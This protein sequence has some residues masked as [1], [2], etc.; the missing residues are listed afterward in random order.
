[1]AEQ[2]S[3]TLAAALQVVDRAGVP[4]RRACRLKD[5]RPALLLKHLALRDGL[6]THRFSQ[7]A[8]HC[9]CCALRSV[10]TACLDGRSCALLLCRC[11]F[12]C[13]SA[14]L[15]VSNSSGKGVSVDGMACALCSNVS[16]DFDGVLSALWGGA[17]RRAD[18]HILPVVAVLACATIAVEFPVSV[19]RVFVSRRPALSCHVRHQNFDRGI[20]VRSFVCEET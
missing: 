5:P 19:C 10:D 14:Q 4:L 7:R 3:S 15:R 8:L 1:M 9:T 13:R 17:D 6:V 20:C 12:R 16:F 18:T 2:R 11:S